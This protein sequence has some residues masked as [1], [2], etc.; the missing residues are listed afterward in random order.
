MALVYDI[1][2]YEAIAVGAAAVGITAAL[3]AVGVNYALITVETQPVRFRMD[4][5]DPTAV[6]GHLLNVG[7]VL[8]LEGGTAVLQFRAIQTAAGASNLRVSLGYRERGMP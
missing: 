4:G 1:N 5:V 2:G 8:E 7:D 6:E 3:L